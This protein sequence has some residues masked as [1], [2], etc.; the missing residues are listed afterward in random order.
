[1]YIK[2]INTVFSSFTTFWYKFTSDSNISLLLMCPHPHKLMSI[3]ILFK[4]KI[5]QS[6]TF[7]KVLSH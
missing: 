3:F 2:L 7:I 4:T 1:M 5:N 6:P